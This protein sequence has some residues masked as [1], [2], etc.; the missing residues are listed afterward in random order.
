MEEY[1]SLPWERAVS[2]WAIS[3]TENGVPSERTPRPSLSENATSAKPNR[4][5]RPCSA[6]TTAA[7]SADCTS[8]APMA[9]CTMKMRSVTLEAACC[10]NVTTCCSAPCLSF[11]SM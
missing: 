9:F 2:G 5:R 4:S 7:G 3:S 11:W 10:V 6:G 8:N 1:E